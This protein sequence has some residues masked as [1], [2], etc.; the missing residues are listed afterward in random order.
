MLRQPEPCHRTA[1]VTMAPMTQPSAH[2]PPSAPHP[3]GTRLRQAR[4]A[5]RPARRSA[6]PLRLFL[7]T[8]LATILVGAALA[9][10]FGSPGE[11]EPEVASTA[12]GPAPVFLDMTGFDATHLIDDDVFYDSTA[13]SSEEVAAFIDQVNDGCVPGTDG[14]DCLA[15]ATF[16]TS[17]IEPTTA[18]P[19]GY[20]GA[21]GETAAAV[22]SQVATTC[23]INPQ[24]I[25]ALLQKEQGLLTA[26]GSTLSAVDYR[27][28]TGYG[29]PDN[30]TCDAAYD[31]F[32]NQV[33]GAAA[34]F[35]RYRLEPD[36]Y[37][38]VVGQST[39]LAYSPLLTCGSAVITVDNQA[40]AGLYDYT[41]YQPNSAARQGGDEC[42]SWGNWSF[43]GYF[44]TWFGDPTPS[45][46]D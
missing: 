44:R 20:A 43:Y 17:D 8:L 22:I 36:A 32:F 46:A 16:D 21:Q 25:L 37:Q 26:S 27:S 6:S 12:G 15:D 10:L 4:P 18:C 39:Q 40:T 14:T 3:S 41:P 2:R 35:Q 13:M 19:G 24:V 33:Y 45:T 34:Q 5:S 38:V 28:A 7:V 23:D 9:A 42:T 11:D 1:Y 31:G 30:A 29:C